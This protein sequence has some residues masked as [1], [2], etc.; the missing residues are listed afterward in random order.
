MV[1]GSK[2]FEEVMTGPEG[3]LADPTRA[4]G[5][6]IDASTVSMDGVEGDPRTGGTRGA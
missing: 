5:L 2:D 3:L 4:P 1:A 6:V